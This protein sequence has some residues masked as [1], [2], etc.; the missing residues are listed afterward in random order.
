MNPRNSNSGT[1]DSQEDSNSQPHSID[2]K[3][4]RVLPSQIHNQIGSKPQP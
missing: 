1:G 2:A 3:A 4:N